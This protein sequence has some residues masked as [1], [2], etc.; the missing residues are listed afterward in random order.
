MLEKVAPGYP[1]AP[2]WCCG[3]DS[4]LYP[5]LA[6][7]PPIPI[8]ASLTCTS[9]KVTGGSE[10]LLLFFLSAKQMPQVQQVPQSRR[11]IRTIVPE[12]TPTAVLV[13]LPFQSLPCCCCW[14]FGAPN[15]QENEST[16]L[17]YAS[18]SWAWLTS[19]LLT[20]MEE[21]RELLR[22]SAGVDV[23]FAFSSP[24]SSWVLFASAT[25]SRVL[26]TA[27]RITGS[28]FVSYVTELQSTSK[29]S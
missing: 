29:N 12:P 1:G 17:Q 2:P 25:F 6:V 28:G 23:E 9:L 22:A 27:S 13:R 5:G 19:S 15:S 20:S 18:F 26:L 3:V 7:T 4:A 14:F 8:P 10:L 21:S 16:S 24:T 11:T